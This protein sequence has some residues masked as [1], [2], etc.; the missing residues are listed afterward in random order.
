MQPYQEWEMVRLIQRYYLPFVLSEKEIP[1]FFSLN[2]GGETVAIAPMARRFG[3]KHPYANFGKA[4][5]VAVKD[6][7][8]SSEMPAEKMKEC[9]LSL[10]DKLGSIHFYDVPEYSLLGK[11]LDNMGRRCKDHIYTTISYRGGYSAYY[12]RL[13]KHMRQNIRTAYNYLEKNGIQYS[14]EIIKGKDL[15]RADE[16]EIMD[17]YLARRGEHNKTDSLIHK[18]YLRNLHYYTIAH[19]KLDSSYFGILRIG[20][21]IAAFWSGFSNP[22]RD[23]IS[24]PRL[25]LDNEFIRCSP[26]IILLCETAKSLEQN[27]G[28]C[29]LDL[30]RGDHDYKILLSAK[31][32]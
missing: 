30:S 13:S 21:K 32:F 24:C 18:L 2:D 8:Y 11:V 31:N 3:D 15:S 25:A 29:Q 28:I 1:V 14:F 27:T 5:T 10:K 6:F 26:G 4:P 22:N 23:Y 7:I 19:R 20:S 12:Q 16:N 17:I 9:L